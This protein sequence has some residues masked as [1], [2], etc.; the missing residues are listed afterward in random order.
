MLPLW[1]RV[2]LGVIAIKG[3]FAFSKSSS[4]IRTSPFDC[5][6]L[7]PGHS[8]WWGV[9]LICRGAVTVFYWAP[10]D[11]TRWTIITRTLQKK[12]YGNCTQGDQKMTG[13]RTPKERNA[14]AVN[15]RLITLQGIDK[16]KKEYIRLKKIAA[17]VSWGR[18]IHWLHLC[19]G[20]RLPYQ[21]SLIWHKTMKWCGSSNTGALGN[22]EYPFIVIALRSTLAWRGS[23]W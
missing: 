10:A 13:R 15:S 11:W 3:Y 22:S 9:L 19:R 1:A 4:I 12:N 23:T 8:L 17:S 6:V 7:Y 2:D 16:K 5:L 21:V 20:I 14:F 18:T